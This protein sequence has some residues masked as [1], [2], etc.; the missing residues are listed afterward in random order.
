MLVLP[1]RIE[2]LRVRDTS[3]SLT[4][5]GQPSAKLTSPRYELSFH[6][7]R[8]NDPVTVIVLV[9]FAFGSLLAAF[10]VF[11][12]RF[13]L[14]QQMLHFVERNAVGRFMIELSVESRFEDE[15]EIPFRN[16]RGLPTSQCNSLLEVDHPHYVPPS[17][18]SRYFGL[19]R[20]LFTSYSITN[21]GP[22]VVETTAVVRHNCQQAVSCDFDV[23]DDED[24]ESSSA[25]PEIVRVLE[26]NIFNTISCRSITEQEYSLI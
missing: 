7:H 24:E 1:P 13:C 23:T 22:T 18:I 10:F 19:F 15:E 12:N 4:P 8:S 9:C 26:G 11:F 17:F 5:T 14:K 20:E 2:G 3:S 25:R 6:G 21:G 16:I